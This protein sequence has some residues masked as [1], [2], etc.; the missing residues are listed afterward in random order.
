MENNELKEV[1]IKNRTRYYFDDLIKSED[2]DVDNILIDKKSNEVILIYDI[3]YKNL[4][5]PKTL[6]I[7]F[8]KIDGFIRIYDGTTYLL[9]F[10]SEKYL[11]QN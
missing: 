7:R 10:G 5:D 6:S 2:L 9:L 1:R 11:Q 3:S 8:E 4:I